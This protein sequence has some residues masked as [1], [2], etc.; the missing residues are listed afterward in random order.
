MKA[1]YLFLS[2]FIKL[3]SKVKNGLARKKNVKIL[4]F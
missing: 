4:L 3:N 2:L 1:L